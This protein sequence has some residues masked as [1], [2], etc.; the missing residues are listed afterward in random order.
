[1]KIWDTAGQ[2]DYDTLRPLSYS[3]THVFLAC[4]NLTSKTSLRNIENKW[5]P[6]LEHYG[7]NVPVILVGCQ[8]DKREAGDGENCVS[9]EEGRK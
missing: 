9:T 8:R 5:M 7:I 3:N 2:E 6:E 1:M 4:F